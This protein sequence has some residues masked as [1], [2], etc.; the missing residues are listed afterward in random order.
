MDVGLDLEN[1]S[2]T[3]FDQEAAA[4]LMARYAV[5]KCENEESNCC[6][7]DLMDGWKS[8]RDFLGISFGTFRKGS[9]CVYPC[10]L[11]S[12]FPENQSRDI[13]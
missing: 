9:F 1:E 4:V 3:G 12:I 11:L 2:R 5:F 8:C 10:S 6:G 13:P 7:M